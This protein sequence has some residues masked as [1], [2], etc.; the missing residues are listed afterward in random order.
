MDELDRRSELAR[1]VTAATQQSC[2]RQSDER[3][4][5]FAAGIDQVRRQIRDHA[6]GAGQ[7]SV[8]NVV[9]CSEVFAQ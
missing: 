2:R 3:P 9:D 5:A 4:D 8:D 6:H 7:I 1:A